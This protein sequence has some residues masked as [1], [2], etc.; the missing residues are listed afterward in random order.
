M[1]IDPSL[2]PSLAL[3]R[4]TIA[5]DIA[6]TL[7]RMKVLEALD[8]N[9]IG[10]GYRRFGK[11]GWALKAKNLP[12]PSFNRIVG[13]EPGDEGELAPALDWYDDNAARPQVE[14]VPAMAEAATS[15][16]LSRLGLA[17]TGFHAALIGSPRA[18]LG[19]A[20]GG[21]ECVR[22]AKS[23]AAFLDAYVVSWGIPEAQHDG[24]KRNV[25]AWSEQPGWSLYFCRVD[26]IPAA[27]AI[28]YV[29]DGAAYLADAATAKAFRGRGL[30][31]ELLRARLAA[32]AASGA[33]IAVS[34]AAFLSQSHRN[35]ERAGMKLQFVRSLWTRV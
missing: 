7:S 12:V 28:L 23:F 21:V 10:I 8:G 15:R 24:F 22:D 3:I 30:H 19:A 6:Y 16:E 35:M 13:F 11:A 31:A 1:S 25:R 34:G 33:D 18:E 5:I 20:P 29:N 4:R 17:T 9:P 27:A 26:G 2:A 32:A 14:I